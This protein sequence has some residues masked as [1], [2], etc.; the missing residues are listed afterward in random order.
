[1]EAAKEEIQKIFHNDISKLTEV[2]A[3]PTNSNTSKVTHCQEGSLTCTT[4][5]EALNN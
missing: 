4:Y 1:M 2:A 3:R 5:A